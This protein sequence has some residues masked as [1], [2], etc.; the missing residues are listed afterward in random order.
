M[1]PGVDSANRQLVIRRAAAS[2]ACTW[3]RYTMRVAQRP[4]VIPLLV[5]LISEKA[6]V[7]ERLGP[8]VSR[9]PSSRHAVTIDHEGL[10]VTH[11]K[12]IARWVLNFNVSYK[13]KW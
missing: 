10:L 3:V 11:R 4:P 13:L 5:S 9:V 2:R 1:L 8:D 6:D 12:E 7:S